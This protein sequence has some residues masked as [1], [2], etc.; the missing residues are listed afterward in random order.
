MGG[1]DTDLNGNVKFAHTENL[2]RM[3]EF[4]TYLFI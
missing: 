3:Q 4:G 1:S 2:G